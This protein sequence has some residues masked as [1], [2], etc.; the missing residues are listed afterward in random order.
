MLV[1]INILLCA[2]IVLVEQD[3]IVRDREYLLTDKHGD[4]EIMHKRCWIFNNIDGKPSKYCT[5]K[6]N[7]QT[8]DLNQGEIDHSKLFVKISDCTKK[9]F[10]E[11][12]P[13]K[14]QNRYT[15]TKCKYFK[16]ENN[17]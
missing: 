1:L 2:E 14:S 17:D 4:K 7:P 16:D 11:K 13:T 12:N 9:I 10:V 8:S 5:I 6:T 15:S 3:Y